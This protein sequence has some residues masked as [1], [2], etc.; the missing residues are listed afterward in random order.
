MALSVVQDTFTPRVGRWAILLKSQATRRAFLMRWGATVRKRAMENALAK[1][2]RR[3]WRD[4]AR[5]VN[6]QAIGPNGVQVG[7]S[8]VAAAQKQYGGIIRAKG[9]AA[10]GADFLTIPIAPEAEGQ[11]A[12]KFAL[13]GRKLFV[14]P[15]SNLLGYMDEESFHPLFALVRQTKPQ[16]AS[17]WWPEPEFIE[18]RGIEQAKAL[19]GF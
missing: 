14:F 18:A 12:S 11:F 1:G 8:H 3:L 16:R 2:G 5:S 9:K 4:I 15:N 17:P 10:G 6:V 7:A 13:A 19:L